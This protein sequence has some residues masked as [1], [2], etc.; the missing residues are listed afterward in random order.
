MFKINRYPGELGYKV[1]CGGTSVAYGIPVD[2]GA[3]QEHPISIPGNYYCAVTAYNDAGESGF[4]KEIFF[5]IRAVPG[6]PTN[7]RLKML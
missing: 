5:I 4:S 7:L 1:Y 2:V 3:P 6:A